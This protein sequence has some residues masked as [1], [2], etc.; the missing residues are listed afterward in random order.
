MKMKKLL[1]VLSVV[2]I[3]LL[4]ATLTASAD[5][6]LEEISADFT[7]VPTIMNMKLVD[8][9]MFLDATDEGSWTGDFTGT[10][11]EEYSVIFHGFAGFFIYDTG[12]YQGRATFDGTV[13]GKQGTL[14]ILFIGHSSGSM[15]DWNGTWRILDGMGEL[16]SVQGNGIW[17]M[18]GPLNVHFEGTV[19]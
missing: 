14:E 5:S 7:Y 13:Q 9:N 11:Y 19:H 18:N 4:G 16:E 10:S 17:Y 3:A 15:D 8:S 1:I 12:F 6:S 2:A